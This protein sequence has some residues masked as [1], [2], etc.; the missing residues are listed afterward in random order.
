MNRASGYFKLGSSCSRKW[1]KIDHCLFSFRPHEVR[2]ARDAAPSSKIAV[3]ITL[4]E[5]AT[6]RRELEE[7]LYFA[8]IKFSAANMPAITCTTFFRADRAICSC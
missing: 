6:G 4:A 1:N 2:R 3:V 8:G 7:K 5:G